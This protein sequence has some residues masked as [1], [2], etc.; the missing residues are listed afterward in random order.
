MSIEK[1]ALNSNDINGNVLNIK[2][3]PLSKIKEVNDLL[4]SENAKKHDIGAIAAS[5]ERYG[6]IDP[7]K[8]DKKLNSGNGG[9][10]FGN[11]RLEAV[12]SLLQKKWAA[13]E[14]PP[15][16]IG[17]DKNGEWCIPVSFGCDSES[18]TAA[19]SL[20][21][22][23]NNLT[24]SGGEYSPL[25]MARI[26]EEGDYLKILKEL[27]QVN[28]L[29]ET[30]DGDDLDLLIAML[31]NNE[32]TSEGDKV[33]ESSEKVELP[34]TEI[35]YGDI[36]K[37]GGC[38]LICGDCKDLSLWEK[39]IAAN[40]VNLVFTSP[41]YASQREYD[42]NSD[43][44]PIKPENYRQWFDDIQKAVAAKLAK[45]G[46]FLINIKEH[47]EEGQRSMYV[48]D[49]HTFM[50]HQARWRWVDELI[51]HKNGLPGK[52]SQRLRD[53]FER[54][55]HYSKN[56]VQFF[57]E[58]AAIEQQDVF[59]FNSPKAE[60]Q[61]IK[62]GKSVMKEIDKKLPGNVI[63]CGVESNPIGHTAAFPTALPDFIIKVYSKIEDTVV[64]IF[65]GS[66]TTLLAAEKLQ[67]KSI[68]FEI[69]PTYCE[70][71]LRRLEEEFSLTRKR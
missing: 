10:V 63:K 70:I 9:I 39:A 16:G 68:G 51:W 6:F 12:A 36:F 66:G 25:D 45:D 49:L 55:Y 61:G 3:L 21:I 40:K 48:H 7:P 52:F 30:V 56:V 38:T 35:K 29:P 64:D 57:P 17:I 59:N 28:E 46:S 8:Y 47:S 4:W 11:G 22:D 18:E 41:P 27:A 14:A 32:L 13:G 26:W 19:K 37:V 71:A 34:E 43:F 23:H 50:I 62:Q 2:Y 60:Q 5:I 24:L 1:F 15:G 42:K 20:A 69:S 53:D 65:S 54:I 67:R 58:Q 31:D 44:V 33:V